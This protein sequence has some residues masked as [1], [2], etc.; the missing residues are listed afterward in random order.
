MKRGQSS[1]ELLL[2]L[3]ISLTILAA[4]VN[5]TTEHVSNLQKEQS[6]NASQESVNRLTR[7]IDYVYRSGPG[8]MREVVISFPQGIDSTLSQLQNNSIILSVYGTS[9]IGSA[10]PSL[11]GVVPTSS[12]LQ[13][14]R[15]ISYVDHVTISLVSLI[16][17]QGSI[18]VAMTRDTNAHTQVTFTNLNSNTTNTTFTLAWTHTLV[19]A[20]VSPSTHNFSSGEQF[21]VD[22]NFSA[23]GTAQGNYVGF[24][25]V[26]SM[27]GATT[28]QLSIPINVEVFAPS[29]TLLTTFPSSLEF[30]TLGADS[31]TQTM[32]ICNL[33]N[34]PIKSISFTPSS[35]T[36]G[37]WVTSIPT[38]SQL[39]GSSCQNI[40]IT[41]TIPLGVS[42]G[43]YVG[44][45]S[46]S[47][48]TGANST[49]LNLTSIVQTM[50]DYFVWDW[51]NAYVNNNT[52]LVDFALQNTSAQQ[53][54]ILSSMAIKGWSACDTQLSTIRTVN[55]EAVNYYNSGS[56]GDNENFPLSSTMTINAG[57]TIDRENL[58]QF[59][60]NVSDDGEQFQPIITF[61]DGSVYTGT[62]FGGGCITDSIPPGSPSSFSAQTG[63]SAESVLLSFTFPGD[64][65]QSGTVSS[66]NIRY[67]N[68]PITTQNQFNAATQAT[69]TGSILA[70]G[71]TSTQLVD[72][73][74]V[75]QT[76][77]FSIQFLDEASNAS[78]LPS[79]LS[80]R[81]RNTFQFSLHDFNISPFAYSFVSPT[82]GQL[83]VNEFR[84]SNFS[85]GSGDLNVYL[86]VTDDYNVNN[87]WYMALGFS[88]TRANSV[89]IWYPSPSTA[90][91]PATTP[92]FVGNPRAVISGTGVDLLSSSSFPTQYRLDG[93]LVSFPN[94]THLYLELFQGFTDMNLIFDQSQT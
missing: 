11:Q 22:L 25:V 42:S 20:T 14:I 91:L 46:I 12:G 34:S 37:T 26:D 83:D 67:S 29:Q 45:L 10:I 52:D 9:V 64:D 72:D 49:I 94:P 30:T 33:G 35:S 63:S 43:T 59:S 56:A 92:Q 8:H 70:A 31:N 1:V 39:N 16:S 78:A 85:L 3:V 68:T 53:P 75:G 24:L 76:H 19:G 69:Y 58:V 77:Y 7:E 57:T 41:L 15:L 38:I 23:G 47:D 50:S 90:G 84:L 2:V 21:S 80:S 36:P 27:I 82:A 81:P 79:S 61:D 55:F 88:T 5:F 6:V 89:R 74:N 54:I 93:A 18:Y 66:V 73:L 40:D 60:N 62:V 32:Q 44:S 13:R 51:T 28:E 71:N 87:N 17:D 86:R 48:Y 65:N 4:L